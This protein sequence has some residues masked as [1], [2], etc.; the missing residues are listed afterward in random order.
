M[1]LE[2]LV[3]DAS[4]AKLLESILPQ[5]LT[6]DSVHSFRIHSYKGIGHVPKGLK[7]KTDA[8][9]RILLD[10]LPRVIAGL[11]RTPGI[12]SI[13]VVLDSDDRD[14]AAFLKSLKELGQTHK[15]EEKTIFRLAI[16]EVEAW[17]LG[18]RSAILAAYPRAKAAVLDK[19]V[20]D[21]VCGTWELLAD[22][23]YPG[24]SA[25]LI[26]VGWPL[27]GQIKF[28]WA[29]RIGPHMTPTNNQSPSFAKLCEALRRLVGGADAMSK[30]T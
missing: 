20:Q 6:P 11:T 25:A 26:K 19:Y 15:S 8:N 9:K 2:V 12:D 22:A 5:F 28:E 17:Y 13:L 4:G 10:Q 29:A 1:H 16:E 27:P 30:A 3:E 24:G 23:I 14:C 21:K 7:P 18:D